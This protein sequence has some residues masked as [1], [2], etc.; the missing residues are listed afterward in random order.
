M[1]VVLGSM[2]LYYTIRSY[3]SLDCIILSYTIS[4]CGGV[5]WGS[6]TYASELLAGLVLYNHPEV[7][8]I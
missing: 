8:R 3:I 1:G 6:M 5:V 2:I 7:D 4:H